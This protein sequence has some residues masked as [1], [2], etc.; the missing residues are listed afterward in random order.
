ME[1]RNAATEGDEELVFLRVEYIGDP[2]PNDVRAAN[3]KA[4]PNSKPYVIKFYPRCIFCHYGC[5][6]D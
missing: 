4:E 1:K 2:V 6:I 3:R 5:G